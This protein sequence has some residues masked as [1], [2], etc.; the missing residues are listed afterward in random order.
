MRGSFTGA[1]VRR[2]GDTMTGALTISAN[3]TPIL[4]ID[5]PDGADYLALDIRRSG[6]MVWHLLEALA[7][8]RF[9]IRDGASVG[10][11]NFQMTDGKMLAGIIPLA[12]MQ[13][14]EVTAQS[15]AAVTVTGV[16]T[17]I[18]VTSSITVAVGDRLLVS[19]RVLFPKGVTA[20]ETQAYLA[21]DSGTAVIQSFDTGIDLMLNVPSQPASSNW[22]PLLFGIFKTTGAGTL[23]LKL[24]GN[25]AGSNAIVAAGAGQIY[26]LHLQGT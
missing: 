22:S 10:R 20:G 11:V 16:D 12:R 7:E 17:I 21:R 1:Y 2:S 14:S 4:T 23:V 8:P 25:S 9:R 15:A 19:G 5:R 24:V 3:V 18:V 6:T 26:A 13:V